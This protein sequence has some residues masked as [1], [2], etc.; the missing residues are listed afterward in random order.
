M[1]DIE[2]T[3]IQ[4]GARWTDTEG[5]GGRDVCVIGTDLLDNVFNGL[6]A[7]SVIG[8]VIRVDGIPYQVIGVADPFGKVLGFSRDNFVYIPFESGLRKIGART[9]ITIHVQVTDESN[10]E[11]AKDEVRAIMRTRRGK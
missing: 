3:T 4:A 10:F 11:A 1:F 7:V 5:L 9:S 2:N 8:E 6:N